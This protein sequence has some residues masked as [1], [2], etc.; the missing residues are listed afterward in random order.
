MIKFLRKTFVISMSHCH[1]SLLGSDFSSKAIASGYSAV[2]PRLQ[3][4]HVA[5]IHRH[6][7]RSQLVRKLGKYSESDA[8]TE[9]WRQQMPREDTMQKMLAAADHRMD[10]VEATADQPACRSLY[11]GWDHK[12]APYCQLTEIGAQQLLAVGRTLRRRYVDSLLAPD[13]AAL[14]GELYCRSTHMCRTMQSLRALLAGLL[15]VGGDSAQ[16]CAA[17]NWPRPVIHTRHQRA[18]DMYPQADGRECGPLQR[19]KAVVNPPPLLA[20]SVAGYAGFEARM[21]GLLGFEDETPVHW[22]HAT[23]VLTCHAA[24]GLQQVAGVTADD[25]RKISDIV[26]WN[27]G[28]WYRVSPLLV[29]VWC[30]AE[31]R[32]TSR[33]TTS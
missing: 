1:A 24:H 3:L 21:R 4:R 8:L 23:D 11:S 29:T 13:R 33:R 2:P 10:G 20:S 26:S 17:D 18:E 9:F 25:L 15:D 27:W 5:V 14:A 7:D 16:C 30:H 32:V 22:M 28:Q 31:P 6:G 12:N 19:R